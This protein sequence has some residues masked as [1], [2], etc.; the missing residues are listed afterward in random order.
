MKPRNIQW[1]RR[2]Y[3][4]V[5]VYNAP[6]PE[7]CLLLPLYAF[8]FLIFASRHKLWVFIELRLGGCSNMHPQYMFAAKLNTTFNVY[9]SSFKLQAY[10]H[11]YFSY[12]YV[13]FHIFS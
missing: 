3:G 7:H 1:K 6:F 11:K 10:Q 13:C 8:V 5:R 12:P 9:S 2:L 4:S